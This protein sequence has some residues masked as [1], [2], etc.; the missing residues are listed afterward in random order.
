M[1][2]NRQLAGKDVFPIGLGGMPMSLAGRPPEER[3]IRADPRG[4]STPA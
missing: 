1:T 3:S 4:A 2:P